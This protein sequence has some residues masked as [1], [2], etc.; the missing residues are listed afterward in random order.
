VLGRLRATPST[1]CYRTALS[2]ILLGLLSICQS[3]ACCARE[4]LQGLKLSPGLRRSTNASWLI[5]CLDVRTPLEQRSLDSLLVTM[6]CSSRLHAMMVITT[7]A[8]VYRPDHTILL[9]CFVGCGIMS[10]I[11]TPIFL[12][13]P[14]RVQGPNRV[15]KICN[16]EN[17]ASCVTTLIVGLTLCTGMAQ[18][19]CTLLP[20]C[21]AAQWVPSS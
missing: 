2:H 12:P 3:E 4:R 10:F 20:A 1:S 17:D 18:L 5:G 21:K 8:K 16:R 13:S 14:N 11:S 19:I 7:C 9:F 15:T 6:Q